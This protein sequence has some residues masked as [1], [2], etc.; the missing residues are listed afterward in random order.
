MSAVFRQTLALCF[1]VLFLYGCPKEN[2]SVLPGEAATDVPVDVVVR[3]TF[4]GTKPIKR[5]FLNK[6][7]FVFTTCPET[8]AADLLAEKPAKDPAEGEAKKEEE[9][10]PPKTEGKA[11][12]YQLVPSKHKAPADPNR[13][14][15]ELVATDVFLVPIPPAADSTPLEPDTEYCVKT[16]ELKDEDNNTYPAQDISFTTVEET[17]FAFEENPRLTW[18]RLATNREFAPADRP[19]FRFNGRVYPGG[20]KA[21][22]CRETERDTTSESDVCGQDVVTSSNLFMGETLTKKDEDKYIVSKFELFAVKVASPGADIRYTVVPGFA[23]EGEVVDSVDP[24]PDAD[25]V[26]DPATHKGK[27]EFEVP[28]ECFQNA[29]PSAEPGLLQS[30]KIKDRVFFFPIDAAADNA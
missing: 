25:D 7:N 6:K 2:V 8:S 26:E 11:V 16:P 13:P 14:G 19:M 23:E 15:V 30:L 12:R 1:F 24:S 9:K 29:C 10:E 27:Y 28:K 21:T 3:I 4:T 5:A 20:V 18:A 22:V 17:D